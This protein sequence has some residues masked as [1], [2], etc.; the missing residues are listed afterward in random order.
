MASS[1]SSLRMLLANMPMSRSLE[2]YYD[3][4]EYISGGNQLRA[5]ACIVG[6]YTQ[7]LLDLVTDLQE[8]EED[9]RRNRSCRNGKPTKSGKHLKGQ[10]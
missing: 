10:K 1:R 7:G 9:E 4:A 3:K 8:P 2:S 5:Q 6:T